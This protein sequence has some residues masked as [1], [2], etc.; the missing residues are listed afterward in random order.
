M[1]VDPS[2]INDSLQVGCS[3]LYEFIKFALL[4]TF[5]ITLLQDFLAL[6]KTVLYRGLVCCFIQVTFLVYH[7]FIWTTHLYWVNYSIYSIIHYHFLGG[8]ISELSEH[9]DDGGDAI[10]CLVS[11]KQAECHLDISTYDST[12]VK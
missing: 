11:K 8:V 1:S 6:L 9:S 5:L 7:S 4:P 2:L 10:L 3:F 12:S